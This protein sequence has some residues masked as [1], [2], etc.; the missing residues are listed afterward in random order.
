MTIVIF[1]YFGLFFGFLTLMLVYYIL[2]EDKEEVDKPFSPHPFISILIAAR[3]EE[4]NIIACLKAVAALQYPPDKMEVLIGDDQSQDATAALAEKFIQGRDNFRLISVT[5]TLG[6]AR[7]KANV[8]AHLAREAQGTFLFIADADVEVPPGWITGMLSQWEEGIG[9]VSG[10]TVVQGKGLFPKMQALEW[11]QAFGVIKMFSDLRVPVT[12]VG[13]NMM[14]LKEAY[15]STGGYE[16]IPFSLTED[17]ELFRHTL[18]KGW[19]FRNLLNS[20][21]LAYSRPITNLGT[22]FH[23]R[24]RWMTGAM[25][26]PKLLVLVLTVQALF[27][28]A[29]V[30]TLFLYPEW[31][32]LVW[33]TKILL[34]QVYVS[35]VLQKI[36]MWPGILKY[37][38]LFEIYSGILTFLSLLNNLLPTAIDWKGRKY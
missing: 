11:A 33:M 8:L 21:V 7:G 25:Q 28:P 14:I 35:L 30:V 29:I 31:A 15:D 22:L 12:A 1:L 10:V 24:K 34:H 36:K 2:E 19:K 6:N 17:F 38:L 20:R 26:L 18:A 23:Q 16:H 37:A 5:S 27:F 3:N 4:A 13:N 32:A 9:I